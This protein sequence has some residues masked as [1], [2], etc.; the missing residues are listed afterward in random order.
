MSALHYLDAIKQP[1]GLSPERPPLNLN[2]RMKTHPLRRATSDTN[3]SY[4][5][6]ARPCSFLPLLRGDFIIK[7][8]R[9]AVSPPARHCSFIGNAESAR[10][11]SFPDSPTLDSV[12]FFARAGQGGNN[13]PPLPS[14]SPFGTSLTSESL[15]WLKRFTVPL[16]RRPLLGL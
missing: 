14:S 6:L 3:L 15:P 7:P 11:L 16:I 2:K 10:A 5:S 1:C 4:D 8:A 13:Y 12:F 9:R